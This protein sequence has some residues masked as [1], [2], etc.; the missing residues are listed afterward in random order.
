[1][2]PALPRLLQT[3]SPNVSSRSAARIRLIVVHD[4]E[5]TYAGAIAWFGQ[6]RSRVSAHLVMRED[7]AEVTQ[8]VPLSEKAWHA[9]NFNSVSVGIEGAGSEAQGFSESWWSGMAAIV[10]WLLHRYGLPCRWAEGGAGEGFCA[11]HDLGPAGGG[12]VDPCAIGSADWT[13]FI[14][15]VEAAY[16]EFGAG[17]LPDWALHGLP[18]PLA[19][20]APPIA[21]AGATSHGGRAGVEPEEDPLKPILVTTSQ[22]TNGD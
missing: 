4:T 17:T 14:C 20:V 11:H 7:G 12:H 22:G 19:V 2:A 21:P 9:C 13:R 1:M 5:G 3:P 15:R 6:A 18:A 8:M 10:A 16:H